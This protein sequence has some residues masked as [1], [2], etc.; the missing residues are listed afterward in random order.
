MLNPKV[1]LSNVDKFTF[2]DRGNMHDPSLKYDL[3]NAMFQS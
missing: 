2:Q 1:F 3:K